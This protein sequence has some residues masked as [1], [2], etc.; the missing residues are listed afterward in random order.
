MWSMRLEG[1]AAALC[2]AV[3]G[4]VAAAPAQD[5]RGHGGPVGALAAQG[6]RVLSGSFDTRAILW[7]GPSATALRVT[8]VHEGPVT[9]VALLPDGGLATGGQDGRVALWAAAGASPARIE[10]AHEAPVAAL[11]LSP[12]LKMLASAGWDGRISL[13]P[14]DGGAVG[15]IAAHQGKTTG[16][17]WLADGRL[18]SV[19]DDLRLRLWTGERLDASVDLPAPPTGMATVGGMSAVIFAD[20]ALRLVDA[21]RGVVATSQL[22][23]RPLVAVA[24]APG[25]LAAA[26]VEGVAYLLDPRDLS[27]RHVLHPGQ[28]PVWA[29]ALSGSGLLTGGADG[30]IRR[31]D[32]ATGAPHGR[33]GSP[34]PTTHDDGSRGAA[35]WRACAVCHALTPDS[36]GRAGPTLHGVFG[37]RIGA[38]D[39]YDYSAALRRMDIVWTPET[40]SALF[41]IGPDAYTPGSRMP[42]QRIADP[43]D[44]A[45][46]VAFLARFSK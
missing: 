45:A 37:R 28:G 44:R 11:A 46:L 27:I 32:V 2:L 13:T 4:G 1:A 18:A 9:A 15:T 7:D 31:W 25:L 34:A 8:R 22:S 3:W 40:V 39:G 42:E 5:L 35:V 26:S 33:G 14:L 29:L 43:A 16:L 24:A 12:D 20:G 17:A 23:A 41:E 19:G 30:L 21:A 38:V 10:S 6:E 36:G